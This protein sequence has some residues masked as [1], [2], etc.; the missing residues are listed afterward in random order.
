M[1]ERKNIQK[2]NMV[3][4]FL[5][6]LWLL[7]GFLILLGVSMTIS[8]KFYNNNWYFIT[9]QILFGYLPGG[10][11]AFLAYKIKL[12]WLKKIS[13]PVLLFILGL[14]VLAL[15]PEIGI[16]LG[17]ARRWVSIGPLTF[18]PSEFLKLAFIVYLAAWLTKNKTG[19]KK[20][21]KAL[22]PFLAILSVVC[23]LLISQPNI[24]TLGVIIAIAFILYFTAETPIRHTI[25]LCIMGA[26]GL[27]L[28]VLTASY[29]LGRFLIF[30]N[31]DLH[32]LGI[33]YQIR[34]SLIAVGSGAIFGS[35]LGL[36]VQKAGFLPQPMSD[37][38]FAIFAEETGFV[39]AMLLIILI[40]VFTWKVFSM[41][42]QCSD[43]FLRLTAI[44]IASWFV[45]QS[46]INIG[47]IIGILPLTGIPLPFVSYGSSHLV[48]ELTAMGILLN[49]SKNIKKH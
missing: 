49:I 6:I 21:I 25:I 41:A 35:G 28:L 3:L 23:I 22:I 44:G 15:T 45:I 5:F 4:L 13:L 20:T 40:L 32:P 26:G 42:K 30:L 19:F 43:S 1:S 36:S 47:A 24:S 12:S 7:L 29:R 39:G 9:H 46:F 31:P 2:P 14:M 33:G 18:Q 11:L 10:I 8:Q 48:A 38:I 27:G 37:T 16:L 17:G 34:Q